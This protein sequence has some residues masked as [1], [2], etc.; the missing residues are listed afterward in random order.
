MNEEATIDWDLIYTM[1]ARTRM[2]LE[3]VLEEK[4]IEYTIEILEQPLIHIDE[5][6][7]AI[8]Y[9]WRNSKYLIFQVNKDFQ[10]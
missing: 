6:K 8:K 9:L 3:D 5:K 1:K 4:F 10:D 7:K 2:A